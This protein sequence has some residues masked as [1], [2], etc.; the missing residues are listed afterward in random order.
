VIAADPQTIQ[1]AHDRLAFREVDFP[2]NYMVAILIAAI[3]TFNLE[4]VMYRRAEWKDSDEVT[5]HVCAIDGE[6]LVRIH[7][8]GPVQFPGHRL[9]GRQ[10][11][12][13]LQAKSQDVKIEP[14]AGK[15]TAVELNITDDSAGLPGSELTWSVQYEIRFA[16]GEVLVVP[17]D[18]ESRRSEDREAVAT[19]VSRFLD[20]A[21]PR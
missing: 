6:R 11:S 21:I 3:P 10:G 2:P 8:T 15:V 13:P 1:A 18:H 12:P 4:T 16:D 7:V 20:A 17:S 14:L 19:F 5:W 9:L